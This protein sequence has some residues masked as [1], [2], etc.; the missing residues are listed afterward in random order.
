M[1]S[2]IFAFMIHVCVLT[3]YIQNY[4]LFIILSSNFVLY[5]IGN[6]IYCK[7][8]VSDF[9]TITII[10]NSFYNCFTKSKY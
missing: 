6:F 5:G 3:I 2:T 1:H 7:V 8:K 9:Y 4:L 10:S